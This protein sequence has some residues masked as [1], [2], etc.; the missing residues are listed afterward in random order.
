MS[1]YIAWNKALLMPNIRESLHALQISFSRAF[2][3]LILFITLTVLVVDL[4][5][6]DIIL[7]LLKSRNIFETDENGVCQLESESIDWMHWLQKRFLAEISEN[8]S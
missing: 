7:L 5:L 4:S 3:F 2:S 1:K 6:Q 8:E